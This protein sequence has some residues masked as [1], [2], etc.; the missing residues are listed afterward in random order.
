MVQSG[1]IKISI[2][3]GGNNLKEFDIKAHWQQVY[4]QKQTNEVSWFQDKPTVS[5]ALIAN[6]GIDTADAIIDVG[7]GASVLVDH[8][9]QQGYTN[10]SVLDISEAA[11]ATNR[12]RLGVA[13][14]N[15]HWI[16]ADITTFA[17]TKRYTLWHDRAVFHFLTTALD[18]Q[19]YV[20]A[21]KNSLQIGGHLLIAAFAIGG[22]EQC[23][24][25]PIVQYNAAKL[26]AELGHGFNLVEECS[27]QHLTPAQRVQQF[28]YF[29]FIRAA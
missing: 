13:A 8:L 21:L 28:A 12:Q 23:S 3:S 18:R 1:Y 29:H 2:Y 9:L 6:C 19:S 4:Q 24:G 26:A 25:L 14:Q 16:E 11:L 7:G 27:E 10:L 5:L 17:S 22:P 15:V 20:S